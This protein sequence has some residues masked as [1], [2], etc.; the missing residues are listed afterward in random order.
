MNVVLL[1]SVIGYIR[2]QDDF[3]FNVEEVEEDIDEILLFYNVFESFSAQE[4]DVLKAELKK[5]ALAEE[6]AEVAR[7]VEEETSGCPPLDIH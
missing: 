7:L 2:S 3:P 4:W 5:L 1:N 6:Q